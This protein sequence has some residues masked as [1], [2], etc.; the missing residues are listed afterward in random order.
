MITNLRRPI[1]YVTD[2]NY[3]GKGEFYMKHLHEGIDLKI[4][5]LKEALEVLYRIWQQKVHLET[6]ITA[7]KAR[8]DPYAWL[9]QRVAHDP[10]A[11]PKQREKEILKGES[12]VFSY[13]GTSHGEDKL[14]DVEIRSPFKWI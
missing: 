4:E 9:R 12:W 13:D 2:A 3:Q 5:S 11:H 14:G 6:V 8:S 7:E 10:Y 1:V